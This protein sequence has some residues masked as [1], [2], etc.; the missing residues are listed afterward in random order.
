VEF[1]RDNWNNFFGEVFVY[2]S[3]TATGQIVWIWNL[4]F[5]FIV[6]SFIPF[7]V[8]LFIYSF[9]SIYTINFSLH[10]DLWNIQKQNQ[11]R[12]VTSNV[13]LSIVNF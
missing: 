9:P 3:N 10:Y 4:L 7:T 13:M 6:H 12:L 5:Y 8:F 2:F 11:F 1:I